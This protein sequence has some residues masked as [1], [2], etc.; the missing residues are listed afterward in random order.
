ME[1][2]NRFKPSGLLALSVL[3]AS[4]LRLSAN[5]FGL[6]DQDAFATARGEAVVATPDAKWGEVPCAFIE[7][8]EGSQVTAEELREFCRSRR[9]LGSKH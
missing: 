5:G 2:M 6:P 7:L 1:L 8:K 3:I 4:A 9:H